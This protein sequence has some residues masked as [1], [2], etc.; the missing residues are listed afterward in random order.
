M[1]VMLR[2]LLVVSLSVLDDVF[3]FYKTVVVGACAWVLSRYRPVLLWLVA[4]L[5]AVVFSIH[6]IVVSWCDGCVVN[7]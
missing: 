2:V 6:A 3:W 4:V 5:L 7:G 1:S